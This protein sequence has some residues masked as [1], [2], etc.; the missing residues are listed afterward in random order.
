[1]EELLKYEFSESARHWI[2]IVFFWSGF[3]AWVG[4]IVQFFDARLHKSSFEQPWLALTLGYISVSLGP[5]IA[6]AYSNNDAFEPVSPPG[7]AAS[8]LVAMVATTLYYVFRFLF[9][10]HEYEE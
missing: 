3:A 2:T 8:F 9:P 5:V 7:I 4:V 1:M 6:R 10:I